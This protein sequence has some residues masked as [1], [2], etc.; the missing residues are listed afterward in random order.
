MSD[1]VSVEQQGN[2]RHLVFN[3]ADK[4]NAFNHELV[5]AV[6]EAAS[7]ATDDADTHCVIVRGAGPTF[8]AG[9]DLAQ[10]GELAT[11][12]DSLAKFRREC[13]EMVNLLEGMP[14]PVVAQI[15]GGCIGLGAELALAC[16][17][18]VM[19]D[20]VKF[21]LPEVKLGLIPDVGGSTR[22][23]AVVGLGNA[24]ELIMTGRLIGA[25]ECHRIGAA[26][27]VAS[28]DGLEG[29][30]QELVDELLAASPLAVG[31]AKRVL[32]HVAKPTTAASLAL[33][34]SLQQTLVGTED[35]LEAGAS[36]M[37]KREPRWTRKT[38]AP[39]HR[40]TV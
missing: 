5:L 33:E 13:I 10:A 28:L 40:E 19:A 34:I 39:Q 23:P 32:D 37:E 30:T 25:A 2:V 36:Y 17:L 15:Q 6:R 8:S 26:N 27:R 11:H 29:S 22:L 3:R 38:P 20:D 4:R 12:T 16:D 7:E 14:K 18:R 21:G 35:F 31:Y 1:L 9:I 24:K